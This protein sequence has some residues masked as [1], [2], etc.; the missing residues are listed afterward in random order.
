MNDQYDRLTSALADRYRI[1]SELG[2]GGMA[3]VYLAEDL[4]HHRKVA[5]KVLRP[6]LA[7]ALGPERFLREIEIAASLT[8]PHILPLY[9]SGEA[10]GFLYYVMPYVEG[11]SLRDRLNRE[12]QLPVDDALQIAREVADALD[13]AHRHDV[14]HRDIKPENILLEERHAVVAD[15]G[16]ARAVD[17]AGG[18][19]LTGP[20]IALGTPEYMSPEQA[21]G[22]G[23]LDGRSDIYSL[24]CVLYE[25][26]GGQP[27]FTG[28]TVESVVHQH[29]SLE[30]RPVTQIRAAVPTGVAAALNR[31][32]AK[33]P[34]DRY[35]TALEFAAAVENATTATPVRRRA[36]L[37][38]IAAVVAGLALAM[39]AVLRDGE[40]GAV[41]SVQQSI[42]VL[43]FANMSPD[44][45]NEYFSDGITEELINA[46]KR[47]AEL[48]VSS[49]TASFAY[50]DSDE[51]V[52]TIGEALQVES[53]LTGNVRFSDD[54][55]RISVQLVGVEANDEIW[56]N[57]YE[58]DVSDIF[59]VQDH[60]ATSI[61]SALGVA[62]GQ[63]EDAQLSRY[64]NNTAAFQFYWQG[65]FHLNRRNPD[66]LRRALGFFSR[67]VEEDPRYAPAYAGIA[68]VWAQIG[69]YAAQPPRS[70]FPLAKAA[71]QQALSLDSALPDAHRAMGQ[72]RL[73][74][75]WDH[76]GAL[77]SFDMAILLESQYTEVFIGRSLYHAAVSRH[78]AAIQ[79]ARQAVRSNPLLVGGQ[80]NLGRVLY[81]ARQFE[82]AIEQL[83]RTLSMDSLYS[84]AY[85]W[86]GLAR[87]HVGQYDEAIGAL[88]TAARLTSNHPLA[89][90][91]LGHVLGVAGRRSRA[92]EILATLETDRQRTFVSEFVLALIHIGLGNRDAAFRH[93]EAAVEERATFLTLLDAEPVFDPV[94]NDSRFLELRTT[95]GLQARE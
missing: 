52:T 29:I 2:S 36:G 43:P 50:K 24:G 49:R 91:G 67:A 60:I 82:D 12:K 68:S 77:A 46:L 64:T 66:A 47:L 4:K 56:S 48:R 51:P 26:L 9:D 84:R 80:G 40:S 86:L 37:V 88:E 16:I 92:L 13:S 39:L 87:M 58:R 11:E 21:A 75:D 90:G 7:A 95:V 70:V 55:I 3:T 15:F 25:M 18:T 20:G 30:P 53:V 59:D 57:V 22:G 19:K 8:H 65:R 42:A 28:A 72:I 93:L 27:P 38:A 34:A 35:R 54:R 89:L 74:Y 32:L 10:D 23:D 44:S 69:S 71:A 61:V 1:E 41:G 78:A 33:T 85:W 45:E 62:L 5:V 79:D 76:A 94:R 14:I 83:E 31:M 63:G 81:M 6:E 17:V 73:F